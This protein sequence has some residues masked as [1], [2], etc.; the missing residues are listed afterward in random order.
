M[1]TSND[2][3]PQTGCEGSFCNRYIFGD[4]HGSEI[5]SSTRNLRVAACDPRE[6]TRPFVRSAGIVSALLIAVSLGNAGELSRPGEAID[7]GD[8]YR[9]KDG[10]RV[11]L[12]RLLNEVAIKHLSSTS[13]DPVLQQ[14]GVERSRLASLASFQSEK[15]NIVDLYHVEDS[16]AV[17]RLL[18]AQDTEIGVFPVLIDRVGRRRVIATD[19]ILVQFAAMVSPPQAAALFNQE[20]LE[21]LVGPVPSARGQGPFTEL[22]DCS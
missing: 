9:L 16:Q 4:S 18:N 5:T 20:G 10:S 14:A 13:I 19:Q 8:S 6:S 7:A 2:A 11:V 12:Q 1:K 15:S 17:D 21:E 3:K 22:N